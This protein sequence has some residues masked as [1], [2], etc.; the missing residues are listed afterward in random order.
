MTGEAEKPFMLIA[1][2]TIEMA[3]P[4]SLASGDSFENPDLGGQ[5]AKTANDEDG[6]DK[7]KGARMLTGLMRDANGLPMIPGAS[8][9]GVLRHLYRE[10][11]G[12]EET[13]PVFGHEDQDGEGARGRIVFGFGCIHGADDVAV[14]SLLP[15]DK[16]IK[17]PLLKALVE[18]MPIR[19]DHVALNARHTVDGR[20]KFERIA[21]PAGARFS[22]ELTMASD[23]KNLQT[24]QKT[25]KVLFGLMETSFFRLGGASARGYGRIKLLRAAID[26]VALKDPA[27]LRE[28]RKQAPSEKL[29]CEIGKNEDVR[30]VAQIAD[31]AV[32]MQLTLRPLHTFRIGTGRTP[33]VTIN[34]PGVVR[35]DGKRS[36]WIDESVSS[37]I[38]STAD[39]SQNGAESK[40]PEIAAVARE[41]RVKPV[42]NSNHGA[43]EKLQLATVRDYQFRNGSSDP[44]DVSS[45]VIP[46]SAIRGP[47]VHRAL[48][49]WNA[50]KGHCIDVS[51]LD[52][53]DGSPDIVEKI[54][55]FEEE[56]NPSLKDWEQR[57]REL[58][59]I[60]G[61][62][63][64]PGDKDLNPEQQLGRASRFL[65]A[66]GELINPVGV[67]KFAHNSIDRF[68]GGARNGAL[69]TQEAVV[70][71]DQT[72]IVVDAVIRP[73]IK[74]QKANGA[75]AAADE[76]Q[77]ADEQWPDG[78]RAALL[79][80]LYDLCSGRIAIGADS[81][82]FCAGD[83]K[84]S[85][86][87]AEQWQEE[88]QALK[89]AHGVNS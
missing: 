43:R 3:T 52:A 64:D 51:K 32:R 42:A 17:D 81:L 45:I 79:N 69:Y 44:L 83:I 15:H 30:H 25:L 5:K 86:D 76:R 6:K 87:G 48:F 23:E 2:C 27:K 35:T 57:P 21:V 13:D 75:G 73:P 50:R 58:S 67:Q 33:A 78:T 22:F 24:D 63:K 1:R 61:A 77:T 31:K 71:D 12:D 88:W 85:G 20:K 26:A 65:V 56:A 55:E 89:S 10:I 47:I 39:N 28:I 68:T 37:Q 53:I 9:R 82:G 66:D 19:R 11:Y 60:F 72:S 46:G 80:A 59:S 7:L 41:S 4:L 70:C 8:L 54:K 62:A 29:P 14:T 36:S 40:T 49:H 34:A 84:W 18:T 16:L 74:T 38:A